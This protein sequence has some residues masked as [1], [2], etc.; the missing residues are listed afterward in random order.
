M[1]RSSDGAGDV[2]LSTLPGPLFL[3]PVL[4]A[5]TMP[6]PRPTPSSPRPEKGI[7]FHR[8]LITLDQR[9]GFSESQFCFLLFL[10]VKS[11]FGPEPKKT[12]KTLQTGDT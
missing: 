5:Y 8:L 6:S 12:K 4:S 2:A 3:W 11:E 7:L 9:L 10:S 1:Q